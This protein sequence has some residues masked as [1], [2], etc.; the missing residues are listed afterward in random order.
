GNET[1]AV[2][3]LVGSGLVLGVV[4]DDLFTNVGMMPAHNAA[5]LVT[6][7]RSASHDPHRLLPFD[8][9][10][11]TALSELRVARV[12][13]GIPPPANPFAALVAAGLGKGA[14]HALVAALLLFLA[15]GIRQARPRV[16]ERKERRA[17]AE[18][19]EATGAFYGRTHAHTHAL[20][21]YGR[22][23]ELRLR[24]IV[25]RG[26]EPATFLASRSGA[27]PKR[28]AELYA[29]ALSA[30]AGDE[31]RGDELAVIEELRRL[32]ER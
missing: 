19:V 30:K 6:L 25:P 13:D 2:K 17:F 1:Y 16:A 24:E 29:R 22:F 20:G 21:A 8:A 14:W 10:G 7:L 4:N 5:A 15:Y 32:L 28:V 18:H 9:S 27:D 31:P 26:V 23:L 11:V 3:R 12:E